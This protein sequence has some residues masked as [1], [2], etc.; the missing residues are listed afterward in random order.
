MPA[1]VNAE[2]K[3]NFLLSD[4]HLVKIDEFIRTRT[5]GI[6]DFEL[7]YQVHRLDHALIVYKF[8]S[9]VTSEQN[10]LAESIDAIRIFGNSEEAQVDLRFNKK[11]G[12]TLSVYFDEKDRALLLAG[13]LKSY[14]NSEVLKSQATRI[15]KF[16]DSRDFFLVTLSIGLPLAML[17]VWWSIPQQPAIISD[18]A[19]DTVR[20][21]YL[22]DVT[23][24]KS[25][26]DFAFP[27]I[28]LPF[29]ILFGS[30]LV[31]PIA[32]LIFMPSTF[33]F[34]KEINRYNRR[35]ALRTQVFWVV[36]V[37]FLI[38]IVASFAFARMA[39]R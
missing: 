39:H 6:N 25:N 3:Q 1:S 31:G 38:S 7:E 21:K 19:S 20:L 8:P 15:L 4:E 35:A 5:E 23:K 27:A 36:I 22:V 11:K 13:D 28:F 29:M 18:Q 37:G 32:K 16:I 10:N 12:V 24:Q 14:L 26:I 33:Y 30:F 2:Y 34:G 17:Y 9:E